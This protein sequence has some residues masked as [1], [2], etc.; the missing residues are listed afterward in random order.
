MAWLTYVLQ[1]AGYSADVMG[2]IEQGKVARRE[3]EVG[4]F[5]IERNAKQEEAYSQRRAIEERRQADLVASR[6]T[7]VA[8]KDGS[9]TDPTVQRIVEDIN[10]EGELR[11]LT[12]L[13]EGDERARGM[14]STADAVRR[15]AVEAQQAYAMQAGSTALTGATDLYAKY[16]GSKAK[17]RAAPK[18]DGLDEAQADWERSTGNYGYG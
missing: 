9:T 5:V 8:A 6:A 7:A 18:I 11:A 13:Y 14:R 1:G 2:S 12:R 17:R 16:G 10:T 3:G 15:G 4:A